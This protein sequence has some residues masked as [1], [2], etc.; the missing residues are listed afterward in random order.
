MHPYSREVYREDKSVVQENPKW[1]MRI[2]QANKVRMMILGEGS[3]L[4]KALGFWN[5]GHR[6]W[7]Y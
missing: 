3:R 1:Y 5:Q 4:R 7:N 6:V 2:S